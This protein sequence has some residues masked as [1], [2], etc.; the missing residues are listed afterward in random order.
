MLSSYKL[1]TASGQDS[2]Y[3]QLHA[4]LLH[5]SSFHHSLQP[6]PQSGHKSGSRTAVS[7]YQ[8]ISLLSPISKVLERIVHNR[9]HRYLQSNCPLSDLQFGF[10][11]GSSTQEVLLSVTNSWHQLLS[12]NRQV[13][14]VF[15]DIKKTFDSVPHDRIMLP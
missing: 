12:T 13:G 10:R 1:K 8:L 6:L 2:R 3:L 4:F 11:R 9:M 14:A 7:N 5:Y 15:F